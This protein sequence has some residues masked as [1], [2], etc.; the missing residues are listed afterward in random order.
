[1]ALNPFFLNGTKSEQGLIQSLVNEQIKMYGI[2]VYYIPRIS[3]RTDN[4]I[5]EVQSSYFERSF[6]IEAYLNNYEGYAGG[7]D[8]M[9]KF[10]ITL[11]NEISLTISKE[12]YEIY[13]SP[14]VKG[15]VDANQEDK[16]DSS[17]PREGDLIY[18]PLGERLFEIKQVIFENPFYQLG[19]NY[20]Y[21][22]KCELFEYED[23]IINTD[24]ENL[25]EKMEEKGHISELIMVSL[26]S[27]AYAEAFVSEYGTINKIYLNNDGF[28]YTSRPSV[29]IDPAPTNQFGFGAISASAVAQTR[30]IGG[31]FFALTDI[32]ISNGGTNY[33]SIP[34]ISI[35]GGG[36]AGAAATC[37]IGTSCIYKIELISQGSSYYDEPEVT[38]SAPVGGGITATAKAEI[39]AN[40]KVSNIYIVN[41]GFGY[42]EAPIIT[43]SDPIQL[44]I[45]TFI[46]GEK[47]IGQKSGATAI[48]KNWTN[49]FDYKDKILAISNIVGTFLPGE[50]V[51]GSSSSA[52]YSIKS[53]NEYNSFDKY[54]QNEDFQIESEKV[55]DTTEKNPFGYY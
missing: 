32:L 7:A 30:R 41:A 46:S 42:T 16:V 1:M 35:T 54:N 10:G 2:D 8:I 26:G 51:V 9:S 33:Q 18:F 27:T 37:S 17:R 4:I 50:S 38:I 39:D 24:I 14:L 36:G 28:G 49:Q 52:R 31:T 40:G 21:E 6:V 43:I 11:K 5:K 3:L 12:R 23:E 53:Y 45:G 20:V 22:L 29:I 55:L 48:V 13:I 19:E 44:G 15:I 47:V 25:Q 34:N